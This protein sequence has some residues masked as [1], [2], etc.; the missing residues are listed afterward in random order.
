M[1][2]TRSI[3]ASRGLGIETG[4]GRRLRCSLSAP[5]LMQRLYKYLKKYHSR[6]LNECCCLARVI[7]FCC[8]KLVNFSWLGTIVTLICGPTRVTSGLLN[9]HLFFYS[10]FYLLLR[11]LEKEKHPSSDCLPVNFMEDYLN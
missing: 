9:L 1:L 2:C 3:P 10:W 4:K 7:C 11:I 8:S 6:F 5:N